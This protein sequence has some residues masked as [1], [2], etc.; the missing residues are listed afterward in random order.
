MKRNNF[1]VALEIGWVMLF[2]AGGDVKSN[3]RFYMFVERERRG[4]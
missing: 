1:S 2:L 4:E 3:V